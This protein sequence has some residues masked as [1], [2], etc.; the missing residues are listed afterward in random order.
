MQNQTTVAATQTPRDANKPPRNEPTT[1]LR[2]V[3][4]QMQA[5]R[6]VAGE[7][8]LT[9]G[10]NGP[11]WSPPRISF[12]CN[13]QKRQRGKQTHNEGHIRYGLLPNSELGLVSRWSAPHRRSQRAGQGSLHSGQAAGATQPTWL[14]PTRLRIALCK[15]R[16][17]L[18][19]VH[20]QPCR[21]SP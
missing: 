1:P 21:C 13:A 11:A 7:D 6:P 14:T 19:A 4:C 18:C 15:R 20:A 17:C 2:E 10:Q 9:N 16:C 12:Y 5:P 3:S 8:G